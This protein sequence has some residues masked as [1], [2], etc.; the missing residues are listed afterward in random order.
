MYPSV[1]L[2]SPVSINIKYGVSELNVT[3]DVS[4]TWFVDATVSCPQ[5]NW[6]PSRPIAQYTV[7]F[8]VHVVS[9][10]IRARLCD[11]RSV[12]MFSGGHELAAL[13]SRVC[14]TYAAATSTGIKSAPSKISNPVELPF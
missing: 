8:V 12:R 6:T 3:P 4:I 11:A 14:K 2:S 10:D 9:N 5:E 7:A 13:V 1:R